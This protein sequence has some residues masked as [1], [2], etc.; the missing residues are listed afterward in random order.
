MSEL[1]GDG[2]V[3]KQLLWEPMGGISFIVTT[4]RISSDRSHHCENLKFSVTTMITSFHHSHHCDN[5][6]SYIFPGVLLPVVR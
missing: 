5:L 6:E 1:M 3:H 2:N 4:E